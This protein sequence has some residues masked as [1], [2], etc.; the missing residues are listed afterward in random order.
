MKSIHID[1]E[2]IPPATKEEEK[3]KALS[4]SY[5]RDAARRQ[6]NNVKLQC[7]QCDFKGRL[8]RLQYHADTFDHDNMY[9]SNNRFHCN[10]CAYS[11]QIRQRVQAHQCSKHP[12][13]LVINKYY[14]DYY[15]KDGMKSERIEHRLVRNEG[16]SI[17][18]DI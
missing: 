17:P 9:Y 7:G 11:A 6:A 18:I 1:K 4:L 14:L 8:G 10:Y 16:R 2:Y 12:D 3:K 15:R 13:E 5:L